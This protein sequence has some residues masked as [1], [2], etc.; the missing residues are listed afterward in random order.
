MLPAVGVPSTFIG[1]DA[2]VDALAELV[3]ACRHS[4]A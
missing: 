4:W 3:D 1:R 2:E